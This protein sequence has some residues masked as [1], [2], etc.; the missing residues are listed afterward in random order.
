MMTAAAYSPYGQGR[1]AARARIARELAMGPVDP[2]APATAVT[3]GGL[4][5]PG[6]PA[7]PRAAQP[8]GGPA[9]AGLQEAAAPAVQPQVQP[10]FAMGPHA[11][12]QESQGQG[13]V[14]RVQ[15]ADPEDISRWIGRRQYKLGKRLMPLFWEQLGNLRDRANA[16]VWDPDHRANF[17]APRLQAM[18]E[19]TR[20]AENA[21]AADA[22]ARG[23]V[24]SSY[25][26]AREGATA[27][28][29]QQG[30]GRMIAEMLDQ[31]S[32]QQEQAQQHLTQLVA[33]A[34]SGNWAQ[35]QNVMMQLAQMDF[36]QQQYR[37]SQQFGVGDF[38]STAAGLA[39]TAGSMGWKPF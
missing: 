16:D 15:N 7:R 33:A 3:Q 17:L 30:R 2:A 25:A 18:D 31:E 10:Q 6:S 37:D 12:T 20:N 19:I 32:R 36:Q 28:A 1:G 24:D 13:R 14:D 22:A 26:A 29:N 8:G 34:Q 4:T 27:S 5:Q 23:M 21:G 39:G 9:V 11:A 35:A 38:L